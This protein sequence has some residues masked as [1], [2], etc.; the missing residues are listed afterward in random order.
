MNNLLLIGGLAAF[1]WWYN[2]DAQK[3]ARFEAENPAP[4]TAEQSE[5]LK[6]IEETRRMYDALRRE[7][8]IL[9]QPVM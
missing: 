8:D 5:L 1:W 9:K 6:R 3:A 2:S 7:F 4:E